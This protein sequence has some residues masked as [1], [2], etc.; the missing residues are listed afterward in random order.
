MPFNV[1]FSKQYWHLRSSTGGFVLTCEPEI[2]SWWPSAFEACILVGAGYG[3]SRRAKVFAA[4]EREPI[5]FNYLC[6]GQREFVYWRRPLVKGDIQDRSVL[7]G[8]EGQRELN[9]L[10][11]RC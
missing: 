2:S 10:V 6:C 7:S 5:V 3:S 8:S 4:V 1:C 11:V 9:T